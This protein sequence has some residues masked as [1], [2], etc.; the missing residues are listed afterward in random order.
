MTERQC[1]HVV[2]QNPSLVVRARHEGLGLFLG[3]DSFTI[4]LWFDFNGFFDVQEIVRASLIHFGLL[5]VGSASQFLFELLYLSLFLFH[6]F[7]FSF[8]TQCLR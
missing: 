2:V 4:V 1:M 5:I 7:A 3:V 8:I 6:F